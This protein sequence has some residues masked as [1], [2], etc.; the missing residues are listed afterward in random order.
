MNKKAHRSIYLVTFCVLLS[1]LSLPKGSTEY[2]QGKTVALLAPAWNH[3][4][5][6]APLSSSGANGD[7]SEKPMPKE[8]FQKLQLENALLREEILHIKNVIQ[9]E[10]DLLTEMKGLLE[11]AQ[12]DLSMKNLKKRHAQELQKLL[13]IALEMV[14][15][16]IIFRSQSSWGS[17][18]WINVGTATNDMLGIHTIA[19]NSPVLV[20]TAVVGVIDYVGKKQARVRLITDSELTPA[21]RVARPDSEEGNNTLYLAKGEIH[22]SGKQ[23]WRTQRSELTGSGFNYDFPDEQGPARDLITGKPI[24]ASSESAPT[25]I[26]QE[27]DLLVTTG[28]DGVFPPNLPIAKVTKVHPLKEGDYYYE[29]EAVPVADHLDDL[30]LVF[31]IPPVGYDEN[32]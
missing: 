12:P 19:K 23:L 8:D 5:G 16:Q 7:T 6:A 24:G 9:H 15:A 25:A 29:L 18:F 3:L 4:I 31:V 26:V 22:G 14:P 30:S 2:L 1:V 10:L 27:G 11:P 17:S 13:K 21:V 32:G 28:L 20:G